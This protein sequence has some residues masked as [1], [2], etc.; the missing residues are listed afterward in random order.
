MSEQ[1]Q[2]LTLVGI[3][4]FIGLAVV[5]VIGYLPSL[6]DGDAVV[7]VY[8]ATFYPDG[9]LVEE[10]E[11]LIRAERFR[12]LFRIWGAPLSVE[13]I[14][15]PYIQPLE[16]DAASGAVGY[17]K[18]YKGSVFVVEPY[19]DQGKIVGDI[20]RLA[21]SNE[22]GSYNPDM[23]GPGS[24]KVRYVFDV[25]PP[26][27]YDDDVGHLNLKLASEHMEYRF[28][29]L[30]FE[31]TGY[32]EKLYPHPPT[33]KVVEQGDSIVVRGRSGEDELIEVEMLLDTDAL[34]A[35][36]GFPRKVDDVRAKTV[37][38]NRATSL[39]YYAALSLS[40]GTRG[41]AL[42]M[43]ALLYVAYHIYGR[44]KDYTVP[45]YLSYVPNKQRKPWVVNQIF[46]R[47]ALD[48]DDDGFYATLLD[49]H[50]RK[51]IRITTK[52]G[53]LLIEII[54]DVVD[55][56]YERRVMG[57][58]QMLAVDGV[59]DTDRIAALTENLKSGAF[60]GEPLALRLRSL[61]VR[62]TTEVDE[63]VA[64]EFIVRGRRRV[65]PF[66]VVA[67]LLLAA[68]I[69]LIVTMSFARFVLVKAVFM[70][71]VPI[72]QSGIALMFPSTLFGKWKG[73]AYREKLEW[74]AFTRHLSD[75]SQM[76]RYAPED[77]SIWGEWLVYGTTLGVGDRV[78]QAMRELDIDIPEVRYVGM[79]PVYFHPF[80][81]AS[82]PSRGRVAG[83]GGGGF[84]GGGAGVR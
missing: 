25:H 55:D 70:S 83:G 40:Y 23:Y 36:G 35:L 34:Q 33:F 8:M 7:E 31:D 77:I 65:I 32:I 68:S 13:P 22:V 26:L 19:S 84:G 37:N 49:L 20:R 53:G 44:E 17:F 29:K 66:V 27:E 12:F 58:L 74:D 59:V 43:P 52:P 61:L 60:E 64:S 80:V 81:V 38:A 47:G 5:A 50:M 1:R 21:E 6:G 41:L 48:Y 76:R 54:D 69:S 15:I 79:M 11:Y 18:D 82:A 46:K 56:R 24:Y 73:D 63:G 16:V 14:D 4:F 42:L 3:T 10:Y 2:V 67:L 57:F 78:V 51:K 45:R 28:V 62:L 39:K 75:L 30:I 9:T 71:F 72:I